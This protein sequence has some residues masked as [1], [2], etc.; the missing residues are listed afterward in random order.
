MMPDDRVPHTPMP[1]G[2]KVTLGFLFMMGSL[3][4]AQLVIALLHAWR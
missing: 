2:M 4:I 3:N 1:K